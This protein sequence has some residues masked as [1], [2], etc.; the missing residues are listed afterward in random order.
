MLPNDVDSSKR[1][2]PEHVNTANLTGE[3]KTVGTTDER[4]IAVLIDTP[5]R[6]SYLK[7][8]VSQTFRGLHRTLKVTR[9]FSFPVQMRH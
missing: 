4:F 8:S 6:C 7:Y 2:L 3:R 5:C 9:A 1:P